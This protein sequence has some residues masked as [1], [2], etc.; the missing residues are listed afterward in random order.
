MLRFRLRL[1]IYWTHFA[2]G[3]EHL[4]ISIYSKFIPDCVCSR[5]ASGMIGNQGSILTEAVFSTVKR[6]SE[7]ALIVKSTFG[8]PIL[9][10]AKILPIHLFIFITGLPTAS[11]VFVLGNSCWSVGRMPPGSVHV[12]TV[13]SG[14]EGGT[15][16]VPCEVCDLVIACREL[17]NNGI[18]SDIPHFNGLRFDATGY[19]HYK[20]RSIRRRDQRDIIELEDLHGKPSTWIYKAAFTPSQRSL[21]LNTTRARGSRTS[22]RRTC[23]SAQ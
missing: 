22:N 1:L 5:S 20:V 21:Q 8:P 15:L 19:N 17:V 12:V 10:I 2:I 14:E 18:P 23:P 7:R 13:R 3:R 16:F 4:R 9:N 6:V 11:V